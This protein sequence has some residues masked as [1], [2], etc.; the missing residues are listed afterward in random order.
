MNCFSERERIGINI[1]I[2]N[3]CCGCAALRCIG[4]RLC[5]LA[6]F[7]SIVGGKI[8]IFFRGTFLLFRI[9]KG[10]SLFFFLL[11][12]SIENRKRF[13]DNADLRKRRFNIY[14]CGWQVVR[15]KDGT[16]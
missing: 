14:I 1:A 12:L 2:L 3:S 15:F 8:F 7:S 16:A 9:F 11:S 4:L 6:W 5:T 13:S 10:A